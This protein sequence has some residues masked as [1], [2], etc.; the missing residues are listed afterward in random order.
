MPTFP[1]SGRFLPAS[2]RRRRTMPTLPTRRGRRRGVSGPRTRRGVRRRGSRNIVGTYTLKPVQPGLGNHI[3]NCGYMT[4]PEARGGRRRALRALWYRTRRG[5]TAMQFN[6]APPA[7]RARSAS[8]RGMAL[9][10]LGRVQRLPSSRAR[11]DRRADHAPHFVTHLQGAPMHSLH[12]KT[13]FITC[14]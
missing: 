7:T 11:P 6:F 13:L 10:I 12:G 1:A 3:A 8:G 2:D 4:H 14:A 5:Y 9:K